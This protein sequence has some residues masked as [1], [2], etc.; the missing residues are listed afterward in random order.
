MDQIQSI[1]DAENIVNIMILLVISSALISCYE[2]YTGN[3]LYHNIRTAWQSNPLSSFRKFMHRDY[4]PASYGAYGN[5][6]DFGLFFTSVF[7]LLFC[8]YFTLKNKKHLL[9]AAALIVMVFL[10]IICTHT[11]GALLA[12]V[13]AFLLSL[14]LIKRRRIT[15]SRYA[16]AFLSF[17]CAAMLIFS[18]TA[19]PHIK[20]SGICSPAGDSFELWSEEDGVFLPYGWH[21]IGKDMEIF[22][23]NDLTKSG[24]YSVGL[25]RNGTNCKLYC[26]FTVEKGIRYWRGKTVTLNCWV[27]ADEPEKARIYITD[28]V[29]ETITSPF[30]PGDSSWRLMEVTTTIGKK[31]KEA[32]VCLQVEGDDACIYFD[33][34]MILDHSAKAL[35]EEQCVDGYME[36]PQG[37][38]FFGIMPRPVYE[39][40]HTHG[41]EL[42]RRSGKIPLELTSPPKT[43]GLQHAQQTQ[44]LLKTHSITSLA[45]RER[46]KAP[47]IRKTPERRK[48]QVKL[49][50]VI[51]Y[52]KEHYIDNI[53]KMRNPSDALMGRLLP[54]RSAI[55]VILK[56]PLL[57]YG[58]GSISKT[59]WLEAPIDMGPDIN[60]YFATIIESGIFAGIA[61]VLVIFISLF[62]LYVGYKNE[63]NSKKEWLR[64]AVLLSILCYSVALFTGNFL[65]SSFCFFALLGVSQ[66]I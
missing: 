63:D 27:Y 41:V 23:E 36:L 30:H 44:I 16:L 6:H 64:F 11:R 61:F 58:I 9:A 15:V 10:G 55:P 42:V 31:A 21:I 39:R 40:V 25:K 60:I 43:P 56:K 45:Q 49:R 35:Y 65:D 53:L 38:R 2:S 8:R 46:K 14:T 32:G 17:L 47:K 3:Y 51:E 33:K 24:A 50:P 59:T 28:G 34:A 54:M 13:I 18:F 29:S 12:V 66:C 5:N 57:G 22:R 4:I 26:D 19:K 37:N 52:F 7:Y 1:K 20:P 62:R 48:E